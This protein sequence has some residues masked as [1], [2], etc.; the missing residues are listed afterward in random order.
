MP[1]DDLV[2]AQHQ[3]TT[4]VQRA[5][6]AIAGGA[7]LFVA[8]AVAGP[9]GRAH[10]AGMQQQQPPSSS[11]VS[12]AGSGNTTRAAAKTSSGSGAAAAAG[13]SAQ[14]VATTSALPSGPPPQQQQ[15]NHNR[16]SNGQQQQQQQQSPQSQQQ[17]QQQQQ[18][19]QQ[20]QQKQPKAGDAAGSTPGDA[21]GAAA[22]AAAAS[23][24]DDDLLPAERRVVALFEA[25]RASVVNVSHVRS[26][27]HFL[28]LDVGRM[29]AGQGTGFIWDRAGHVVVAAHTVRGASEVKVTLADATT[30]TARVVGADAAS[31]IA[32]LQL[33]LPRTRTE[34]LRP[35]PLGS[36]AGLRVGQSVYVVGN[37]WGLEHTL[38]AGVVS[39]LGRE[40]GA[41]LWALKGAVATDAAV[42]AG[43]SGGPLLDSRGR[44]VGVAI[45]PPDA[46]R[47]GGAAGA[48][49]HAVPIDAV[50]RVVEQLLAHGRVKRPSLGVVLAPPQVLRALGADGGG[51]LVL[52]VPAA[53]P[54]AAAGLR[55]TYRD[56]F[57]DVVL[58]DVIGAAAQRDCLLCGEV[59]CCCLF[60]LRPRPQTLKT[61]HMHP[62][63][64]TQH[65]RHRHAPRAH[66][67]RAHRGARGQ[68]PRRPR[69]LRRAARRQALIDDGQPRRRRRHAAL[70]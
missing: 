66:R 64:P 40:M 15:H 56:V 14:H 37:P 68:A 48:G 34:A 19:P 12:K 45:A 54:A 60:L 42:N 62:T 50:R 16:G 23:A 9:V 46:G 20:Q 11:T 43:N 39:G 3:R 21:D 8:A 1:D 57:G 2:Q 51:V 69:A 29:S 35:V 6:R 31:D 28:T 59:C 63:Q 32:V 25:A 53:S 13:S 5:A 4:W 30:A 33:A 41:G 49:G 70:I 67:R 55:A 52:E 65:S 7:L 44:A 61:V 38:S 18:D 24:A 27:H 17:P 58:G 22:A 26:M 10:A 36:S 47:G